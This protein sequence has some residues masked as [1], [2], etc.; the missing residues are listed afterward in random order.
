MKTPDDVPEQVR[1]AQWLWWSGSFG[2]TLLI[3]GF[4]LYVSGALPP[5]VPVGELP[6]VWKMS[7]RELAE[8]VGGHAG[9]DWVLLPHKGDMLNLFGIAVLS[10]CS[11]LPLLAAS[12]IYL[13]RGD[14]LF[15]GLCLAQVAVLVLAASGIIA[16]GH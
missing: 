16:V 3:V 11:A 2:L 15:A 7:S 6:M 4:V 10:G 5:H 14:R 9:W 12:V 1:Y 13:R 8:H